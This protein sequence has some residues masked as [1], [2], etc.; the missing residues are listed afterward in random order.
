MLT[1]EFLIARASFYPLLSFLISNYILKC[2]NIALWY[3]YGCGVVY[4]CSDCYKYSLVKFNYLN[5][6]NLS[7]NSSKR[8]RNFATENC[9]NKGL[10][11]VFERYI[12]HIFLDV[13]SWFY[14]LT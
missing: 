6:V 12:I 11:L 10:D 3:K 2:F 1:C 9:F 8:D 4:I 13:V 5:L 14:E 7:E